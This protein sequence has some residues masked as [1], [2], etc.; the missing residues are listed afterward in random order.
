MMKNYSPVTRLFVSILLGIAALQA[1]T[2]PADSP[3]VQIEGRYALSDDGSVCE[4]YPGV[5]TRVRFD[6]SS[7]IMKAESN[8]GDLYIDVSVDGEEN[9]DLL[10]A[11]GANQITLFHGERG[12][13]LIEITK[14]VQTWR[15]LLTIS[16]FDCPDGEILEVPALPEKKLLFIG[17]SITCGEACDIREGMPQSGAFIDNGRLSYGTLIARKLNAQCHLVSYGGRGIIRDWRGIRA[18]ANAPVFYDRTLAD[19][20]QSVWNPERYIPD[21]IGVC[22]GQNDFNQGIPDQNEFVNAYVE[23]IRK[24]MRDAPNAEVILIESPMHGTE[25]ADG[26][27][28]QALSMY[29]DKVVSSVNRPNIRH[30]HLGNYPGRPEN[31]HPI[32]SEHE[33]IADVLTPYFAEALGIAT[34]VAK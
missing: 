11:K 32:A 14:R 33:Q 34:V 10:L 5:V 30:V 16:S 7:L 3:L 20:P 29:L 1:E 6:G 23:F 24:L 8:S 18:I 25:G 21:A 22:L 2:I 27:K 13:H 9:D 19:D 4:G 12:E 28:R 15:G 31:A 26:V 17:D